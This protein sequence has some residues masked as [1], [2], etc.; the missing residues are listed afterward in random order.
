MFWLVL[1]LMLVFLGGG[2]WVIATGG[3]KN[4]PKWAVFRRFRYAHRGLHDQE[5][6]V[7]ENSLPAFQRAI[8]HGYG[9]EL[10]VHLTGDGR[11]AVIHDKNLKRTTGVD[12]EV[13]SLSP[14]ELKK[15][16]LE[17]T[18]ESIPLLEEVLPMFQG[19]LRFW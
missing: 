9:V 18:G 6:G 5:A 4:H 17:G 2:L 13:S 19:G 12:A 8:E 14:A 15:F 10:D 7:P 11:L 1:I 3:R 16:R